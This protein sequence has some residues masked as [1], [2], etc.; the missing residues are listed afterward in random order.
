[1]RLQ[2]ALL[3]IILFA[4]LLAAPLTVG[5]LAPNQDAIST[6]EF[7][8]PA[9]LPPL[10]RSYADW[11]EF[12]RRF[13]AY[14][15]DHF[16]LRRI[17]IQLYASLSHIALRSGNADVLVGRD[18]A[19]FIRNNSMLQQS[20]GLILRQASID[21]TA[22]LLAHMQQALAASHVPMLVAMPPN[23]ATVTPDLLPKWARNQGVPTEYDRMLAAVTARGIKAIDLRPPERAAR[24]YGS[25]YAKYDTHWLIRGALAAFNAIAAS[26][27]RASW[28]LTE[29]SALAAPSMFPGSD[30]A[31]MLGISADV[32]EMWQSS[33]LPTGTPKSLELASG[34][35]LITES[36]DAGSTLLILGDSFTAWQMNAML[37]PHFGR[38]AWVYHQQCGFDW[39]WFTRLHPDE[40]WWMPTE[41]YMLC[42]SR[43]LH[44]PK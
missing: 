15:G 31:R 17:L 3:R 16:G 36:G 19:L 1:V 4:A 18:G 32:S 28:Q 12:P 35:A 33:S 34:P 26:T 37:L 40:V 43:P 39:D 42:N 20:A 2:P 25:V 38:V 6:D 14:L 29:A 27:G 30:L 9:I 11:R 21:Q 13:D 41:R 10:P 24:R 5:V 23:S 22:D 44:M 7:R 8:A